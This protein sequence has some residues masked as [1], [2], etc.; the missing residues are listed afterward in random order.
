M[1]ELGSIVYVLLV[2]NEGMKI[3][4]G[5]GPREQLSRESV[6]GFKSLQGGFESHYMKL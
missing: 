1:A 3:S 4:G 2:L 6:A 5:V